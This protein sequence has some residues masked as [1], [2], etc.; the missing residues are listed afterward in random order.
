MAY[1]NSRG[2]RGSVLEEIINLT[3]DYYLRHN[4]AV[5]QKIPTS[6][7]PVQFDK[8]KGVI[9]LAYFEQKS[10]VDYM[11]SVQGIPVCFDAKETTKKVS[12]VQYS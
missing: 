6:I 12:P 10:T 5:I 9:N 11:G 8:S 3:N 1:W 7:T 4:L 2:L